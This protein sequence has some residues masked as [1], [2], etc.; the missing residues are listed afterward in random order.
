MAERHHVLINGLSVGSG[1]GYT[2]AREL[3]RHLA[4]ARPDWTFTLAVTEGNKLH[5]QLRSETLPSNA[6]LHWAPPDTGRWLA[7][8][9][10]ENAGLR[11]WAFEHRVTRLLQ[12]NG[13][14]PS[15]MTLPTLAHNQDPFPYRPEA[16]EGKAAPFIAFV[17][18]RAHKSALQRAAVV[19]FTSAYLRD[20][21][22][23]RLQVTPKSSHVFYNGLPDDWIA[24]TFEPLPDLTHRPMELLSVSNVAPYK[25]Q[26]LVIKALPALLKRPGLSELVY[27]I[28]GACDDGERTRLTRLAAELGVERHVVIEGRVPDARVTELLGRAR[29]FV[30]M[31]VCE[32]FGIPAIE[33]MSYGVPVV[34]SD[35]CAMP[36]VCGD[37][38]EL[39]PVD[40]VSGLADRVGRVLTDEA[41]AAELR[42]RGAVRVRAFTWTETA[43]G[44]ADALEKV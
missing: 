28:A 32:S 40:D 8:A 1:G 6:K 15:R 36:E 27:R 34:T 30:L 4:I 5:E 19:G 37:G 21:M 31:S 43:R 2:V 13:M 11:D 22:Q 14:I 9:R 35:C 39:C 7:R 20:L 41:Y 18:R 42:S 44:M 3:L 16:W 12:L 33:A 17:K 24:R 29:C 10:Y 25:R 38:A 23:S 26:D